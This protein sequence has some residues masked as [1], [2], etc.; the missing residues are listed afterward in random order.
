[1]KLILAS[2][3]PRRIALLREAGYDP[4]VRQADIDEDRFLNK[5]NPRELARF[6]AQAKADH[7]AEEFPDDVTLAAD[8]IVAFGDLALGKPATAADARAMIRLLSGT[9]QVVITSLAV[10]CPA[11]D[12]KEGAVAMSLVRMHRLKADEVEQYVASG[13]WQGK[14]GGYGIQ[15]PHPIVTCTA[16]SVD[17]VI[18][19]PM[20]ETHDLL[21]RAGINPKAS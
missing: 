8:T 19:L 6:L 17:N 14:A 16:G 11:R 3:S 21:R 13:L 9:T 15:D 2:A 20:K 4:V 10:V 5:M 12:F 1:V 18:G 7:V